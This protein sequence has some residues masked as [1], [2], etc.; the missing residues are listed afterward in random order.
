VQL[1][2]QWFSFYSKI[3]INNYYRTS[4]TSRLEHSDILNKLNIMK[5]NLL[6]IDCDVQKSLHD[7]SG[8]KERLINI[9]SES[10]T[11]STCK[12]NTNIIGQQMMNDQ[13]LSLQKAVA[14]KQAELEQVLGEKNSMAIRVKSL[15][16]F[17]KHNIC[18]KYFVF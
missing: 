17:F 8:F 14:C 6:S 15:E 10:F 18:T 7:L 3:Y 5:S 2:Q 12:D 9:D 11:E 1:L 13:M 16:V 4:S